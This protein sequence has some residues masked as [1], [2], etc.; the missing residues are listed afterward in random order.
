MEK[1]FSTSFSYRFRLYSAL[2]RFFIIF[3]RPTE[4]K[5]TETRPLMARRIRRILLVCNNYDKFALEED[6]R[7]GPR[8]AAE[9]SELNLSNPPEL[10]RAE[11]TVDAL[12]RLEKGDRFD[13][14]ITMYYVGEVERFGRYLEAQKIE[15]VDEV[16]AYHVRDWQMEL[17]SAGE[18]VGTVLKQLAALRA[19]FKYLRRQG[20][21][22]R[23][24]MA[25]I[26]PPKTPKRLPV[27]FREK[28]VERIYA[29]MFPHT[30]DG[31]MEKLVLRML[32]ETGMR[33][34]ELAML[35]L[36]G[37]DLSAGSIKVRG[38]GDKERIIPIE[39]E[40]AQNISRFLTLREEKIEELKCA[41][42]HYEETDRL[43]I[44][45][46]GRAVSD[47]MI[48]LIVKRYMSPITTAERVSP[49]VFRHSF[50]THMLNE[51]A[52]IDAIKEL[53]GHSDLGTTEVYTHVAREHL[54]ETYKHAHPRA[55]K[56]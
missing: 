18:A 10:V 11:S 47:G 34:S 49:H 25:K 36:G 28:E 32:Y 30:F 45:G 42:E 13:L 21:C 38:K 14:V 27:F 7:L 23:D 43:L 35:R 44:N 26:T 33:R 12:K 48:Y 54:K 20:Y 51:G 50:A 46:K 29:D 39:N 31:E 9:Y 15:E 4:A 56:K 6:G 2:E 40:L 52:N 19:W 55:N 8:I 3:V 22:E 1:Q 16:E 53:L 37:L 5:M 41:D 17:M 24:I